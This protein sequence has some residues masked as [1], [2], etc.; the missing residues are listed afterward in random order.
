M[1]TREKALITSAVLLGAVAE[2]INASAASNGGGGIT[3]AQLIDIKR[4]IKAEM[5]RRCRNGSLTAYAGS[6]YDFTET[7]AQGKPIKA[8]HGQKTAGLLQ[9]IKDYGFSGIQEGAKIPDGFNNANLVAILNELEAEPM[10]YQGKSSCNSACS[11]LCTSNCWD[12]CTGCT[13]CTS[14][15]GCSGCYGDCGTGCGPCSGC[16]S[17]CAGCTNSCLGCE[18]CSYTCGFSTSSC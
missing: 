8:E 9:N 18:G 11:G 3:P 6:Q 1:D 15:S 5:T 17:A 7:P 4:R 14:C 16:T 12:S 10:Q 13:S 2:G